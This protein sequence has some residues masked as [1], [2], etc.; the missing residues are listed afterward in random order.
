[1]TKHQVCKH[2]SQDVCSFVSMIEELGKPFE[3]EGMDLVV[4]DTKEIADLSAIESVRN[5]NR[6]GQEQFH[7]FTKECLVERTKPIYDVIRRNK[8]KVFSTS[9]PRSVSKG[10]QQ[11]ASLKNDL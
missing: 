6:I 2:S 1:M 8:V 10:K 4:L 5:V 3:E 9:S 7:A 11:V